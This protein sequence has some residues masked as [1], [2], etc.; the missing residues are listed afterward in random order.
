M[1]NNVSIKLDSDLHIEFNKEYNP[2]LE[3]ISIYI[4]AGDTAQGL[5]GIKWC[6]A[7]LEEYKELNIIFVLGNHCYYGQNICSL[8]DKMLNYL[9]ENNITRLHVIQNSSVVLNGIRFI[10][11]TLWSSFNDASTTAM[12]D[13]CQ[14]MND[15]RVIRDGEMQGRLRPERTLKLHNIAKEFIFT[16]LD[17]YKDD[18]C[19]VVT[20][21]KPYRSNFDYLSPAFESD[22]TYLFNTCKNLPKYWMYGHSHLSDRTT[23]SYTNGVVNFISNPLGYP[24]EL[25]RTS[26]SERYCLYFQEI[27]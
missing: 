25:N 10:G 20:H 6:A 14:G 16:E 26:H 12:R 18:F 1:I 17:K 9:R 23:I 7:L 4:L 19:I 15:Y 8:Y 2:E 22:M 24:H 21:H 11:S 5:K 13:A 27:G 3:D